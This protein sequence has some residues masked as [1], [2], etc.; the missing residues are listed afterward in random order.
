MPRIKLATIL[1]ATALLLPVAA[2]AAVGDTSTLVSKIYGFDGYPATSAY[3]DAP[4]GFALGTDGKT[5]F[6]ADTMNNAIRQLG[7]D[8]KLTTYSGNGRY[9]T[10]DG[11]R[12]TATWANPQ[13]ITVAADGTIYVTDAGSSTLRRIKKDA[14]TTLPTA[15]LKRPNAVVAAD[16]YL[17]IL[18]SGNSRIVR[19][20]L[21]GTKAK[22]IARGLTT[23]AKMQLL[24]GVLYITEVDAGQVRAIQLSDLAKTTLASGLTQPRSI[25]AYQDMLYVTSGASGIYNEV[26]RIDPSSGA[27]TMLVREIETETLNKTSDLLVSDRDGEAKFYMLQTGGSAIFTL[28]LSATTYT[29]FAG[30]HRFGDEMGAFSNAIVG[31]PTAIAASP[32]GNILYAFYA[33]GNKIAKIDKSTKQVSFL[34][35]HLMDNYR[36]GVA[37]DARFSG[38]AGIAVSPDGRTLYVSDRNSQRIR[39]VDIASRSTSYLTGSGPVNLL[40]EAGIIDVTLKN[41][42]AEGS[43]C[44]ENYVRDVA[45]CAYFDRPTG[46]A[47]SPDGST[48]YVADG[49]NNRIRRVNV[50]TGATALVAGS[51]AAGFV[52]G[53]GEAA[54]FK[55]PYGIAVSADG[56]TLYVAD[57]G[58]HAIRAIELSTGTVTTVAG[59]GRIGYRDGKVNQAVFAIPEYVTV[60]NRGY[61]YV[62]ESGSQRIRK[63]DLAKG[64]VSTI[65]G[66]GSRGATNGKSAKASWNNPKGLVAIENNLFVSDSMNDLIRQVK[67]K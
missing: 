47:I 32:D 29:L 46:V 18:D 39:A 25:T 54:R 30:R 62:S 64:K 2:F 12:Q 17:Y 51:G 11:S 19:T 5:I 61:L 58:N 4:E 57:K 13:G 24:N 7:T 27:K 56:A 55:G 38:A 43:P 31:R 59:K 36:E 14:V 8:G 28:D 53:V 63:I 16:K 48:L 34:A 65:S 41:G 35:G 67:L 26:W 6:I 1:S 23:A 45:G 37:G 44:T 15:G 21:N 50:T 20:D 52:N 60:D 49:S 10:A 22:T 66:N 33:Q 42:Y 40:N 3:L 9:G